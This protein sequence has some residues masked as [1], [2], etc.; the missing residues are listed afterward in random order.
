MKKTLIGIGA[1]I[2]VVA[3]AGCLGAGGETERTGLGTG[4]EI[5]DFWVEPS[6]IDARED[7]F[8]SLEVQ[9]DGDFDARNVQ[10]SIIRL[11]AFDLKE[12]TYVYDNV[13]DKPLGDSIIPFIYNW[14]VVAPDVDQSRTEDLQARIAYDYETLASAKIHFVPQDMLRE[15]GIEAFPAESI[16]TSGPLQI[17]LEASQPITIRP[18]EI[19]IKNNSEYVDKPV[20]ISITITNVGPGRVES[21]AGGVQCSGQDLDCIDSVKIIG[22][23]DGCELLARDLG[24]DTD[25]DSLS[26]DY[27]LTVGADPNNKDTDGDLVDDGVEIEYG[28]DPTKPDTDDDGISDYDELIGIYGVIPTATASS[29]GNLLY[30][31]EVG[32]RM[33]QGTEARK[34]YAKTFHIEDVRADTV[35]LFEVQAKYRYRVDSPVLTVPVETLR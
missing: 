8:L 5:L 20:R 19:L 30:V 27:E 34:T 26:D 10:A 15:Q 6:T 11:G 25:G 3:L 21:Q 4:L 24:T 33:S 18:T 28:L 12:E 13:M 22:R 7:G 35:C 17:E 29:R 1:L 16:S 2:L 14:W 23:T 9:N 32:M 31:N